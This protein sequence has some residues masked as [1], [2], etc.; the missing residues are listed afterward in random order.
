MIDEN[1]KTAVDVDTDTNLVYWLIFSFISAAIFAKFAKGAC[2]F[3][4]ISFSW[5][6]LWMLFTQSW[7]TM[8]RH[9]REVGMIAVASLIGWFIGTFIFWR[10]RDW[11]N[12]F[13][14]VCDA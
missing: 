12:G 1:D 7:S 8:E 6:F 3:L 4:F 9:P 2:A 11:R 14:E 10:K 5:I 13:F